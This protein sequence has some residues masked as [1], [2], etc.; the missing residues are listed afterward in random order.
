MKVCESDERFWVYIKSI[1][2]DKITGLVANTLI[3]DTLLKY[4]D[5]GTFEYRHVYDFQTADDP[6]CDSEEGNLQGVHD[7]CN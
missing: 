1:S 4:K 3:G 2:G 6:S 5:E 7:T